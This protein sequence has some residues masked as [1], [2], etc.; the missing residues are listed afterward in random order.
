MDSSR[1]NMTI[2]D[3]RW[4]DFQDAIDERGRLTAVEGGNQIPFQIARVFYVHH[5]PEGVDRGGHAHRD[6]DQ[7]LTCVHGSM[8]VDASDGRRS[9]T[10][11]LDSPARGIYVPRMLYVRL[12]D[13]SPGAVL[14]ALANTCYDA[15]RSLRTWPEYLAARGLPDSPEP[16][17]TTS[18]ASFDDFGRS[19]RLS[20]VNIFRDSALAVEGCVSQKDFEEWLDER[21]AS[22]SFSITKVPLSDLQG[23]HIEAESGNLAHN[24]GRFFQVEGLDI[25]TTFGPT[26]H[27][28]QPIIIQPE[29]GI[30]GFVSKKIEGVLHFLVQAKMEP[31]NLNTLQLSPTVQATRSNY[32]QV[33][34]GKRPPYLDLF[35]DRSKARV[36]V[37][38]LQSEQGARFLRK[39]NR[40]MIVELN[41]NEQIEVLEDFCW[42]TL[43][44]LFEL[45]LRDNLVNMD[46]RTVLSCVRFADL[47]EYCREDNWA[48]GGFG[49]SVY[50]SSTVA[51]VVAVNSMNDLVSWLTR[52]KTHYELTA[53]R[54]PMANVEDWLFDGTQIRHK[55]GKFFSVVGVSVQASNREVGSWQQPLLESVKGGVLAFVCQRKKGVIH[56]LVQARV[57]PGNF[58]CVEMA[59]TLQC[60]VGNY[61]RQRPGT[62]PPFLDTVLNARPDQ[63]RYSAFQ[64]EE[65][66]R[67]YHDEN[68]YVVVELDEG[69]EI[70]LLD[71]YAWMTMAQMKEF[72]RFNNYFN[73]EARGL[74]SCLA[75]RRPAALSSGAS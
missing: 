9:G 12:Y 68:R 33:H 69:H 19:Q 61:D 23:W 18:E 44:Q 7:V 67:F 64:S 3:I 49:E 75:I 65:G 22:N 31:G 36:L 38:Q 42:L 26:R 8:K 52:M 56:F 4:L 25:T 11:E 50:V 27:W 2:N 17:A 28:M 53:T 34:G 73:I 58:D 39:R 32:T 57:E 46:S 29:I 47:A 48:A 24:S 1:N 6:T 62:L 37:D 43:G 16:S 10:F 45:L 20:Q 70:Q 55:D 13:F 14:L 40:N 30:L 72:I 41:E 15:T 35:L 21:R 60:T 71:N 63:I 5:V 74:I 51:D 59:P 54:I 66:G